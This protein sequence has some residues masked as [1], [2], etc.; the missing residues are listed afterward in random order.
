MYL[1]YNMMLIYVYIVKWLLSHQADISLPHVVMILFLW[2]EHLWYFLS[3]F[4]VYRY[5]LSFW[6]IIYLSNICYLKLYK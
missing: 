5:L 6:S 1:R 2:W 3:K 4:Q